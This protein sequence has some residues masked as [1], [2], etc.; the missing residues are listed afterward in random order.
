MVYKRSSIT[1]VVLWGFELCLYF[2]VFG[3]GR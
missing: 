1:H 2:Y 3:M